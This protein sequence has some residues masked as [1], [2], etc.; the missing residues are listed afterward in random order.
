MAIDTTSRVTKRIPASNPNLRTR[1]GEPQWRVVDKAFNTYY[2]G[3]DAKIYFGGVW[4]DEIVTIGYGMQEAVVPH[5]GYADYT[6]RR[7]SHGQRQVQGQ[8]TVNFKSGTYILEVLDFVRKSVDERK[9]AI[10]GAT[11]EGLPSKELDEGHLIY[12]VARAAKSR[13][14]TVDQFMA[15]IVVGQ[16]GL[17]YNQDVIDEFNRMGWGAPGVVAEDLAKWKIADWVPSDPLEDFEVSPSQ[18]PAGWGPG[19]P[20]F[21]MTHVYP[22][23]AAKGSIVA[24]PPMQ[25]VLYKVAALQRLAAGLDEA[26]F[27]AL[28][29]GFEIR[30]DFGEPPGKMSYVA[31]PTQDYEDTY[32]VQRQGISIGTT[33]RLIGCEITG[34][35]TVVD[36][37][38]RPILESYG[39]LSRSII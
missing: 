11:G 10:E 13:D 23:Q 30:I 17:E 25:N 27:A 32:S 2:S 39:F 29:S 21:E 14:C 36:D 19:L 12:E 7:A 38:G 3:L 1:P 28:D 33:K 8:F 37:S 9:R 6:F 34:V 26:A 15:A 16:Q 5:F 4:V 18:W 35:Q 31:E 22:G 20:P 24:G